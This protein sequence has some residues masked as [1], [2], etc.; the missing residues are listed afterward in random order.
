[1]AHRSKLIPSKN[2]AGNALGVKCFGCWKMCHP[3]KSLSTFLVS[4]TWHLTRNDLLHISFTKNA[5]VFLKMLFF[6]RFPCVSWWCVLRFTQFFCRITQDEHLGADHRTSR[7]EKATL[8]KRRILGCPW[9][10]WIPEFHGVLVSS[11]SFASVIW[12]GK[13]AHPSSYGLG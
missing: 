5:K 13:L 10:K 3:N 7:G 11:V 12:L 2:P 9:L 4:E 1:M 8:L 6:S